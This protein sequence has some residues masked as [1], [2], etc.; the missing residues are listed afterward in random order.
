MYLV[1]M[2]PDILRPGILDE[3]F[4]CTGAANQSV[5]GTDNMSRA[6]FTFFF[7][8]SHVYSHR[9]IDDYHTELRRLAQHPLNLGSFAPFEVK[10]RTITRRPWPGAQ[11]QERKEYLRRGRVQ[12]AV[13]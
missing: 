13:E 12:V 2:E 8:P 6:R 7:I 3:I 9:R 10:K 4:V 1:D 11:I 5:Y